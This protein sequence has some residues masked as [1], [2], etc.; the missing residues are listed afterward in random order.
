M[1]NSEIASI[2][3]RMADILEFKGELIFK[4]NAY[5]KA[6]RVLL[7]GAEDIEILAAQ[8]RL[9]ELPGIGKAIQE[10]ILEYLREK[11][12]AKYEELLATVPRELFELLSIPNYGPKTA[13]LAY[14]ELGIETLQDLKAAIDK[15]SLRDLPG[16]GDKKVEK[17]RQGIELRESASERISIGIALPIVEEVISYLRA[18]GGDRILQIAPAGS[19]R[20]FR[21][22]VHDID[23]LVETAVSA[24]IIR[25]FTEMPQVT[26][27][28]AAGE[29]KGSVLLDDRFQVDLRAVSPGSFGAA[30]QYFTGSKEHNVRLR[31]LARKKGLKINE[32]G[33]FAGEDKVAGEDEEALYAY[34]GMAWIAPEL[35]EDRGE[36]EAAVAQHLPNLVHLNELLGDLHIHSNQSDGHLTMEDMAAAV[37][38]RGYRY[39]AFCDHSQSAFYANG[40]SSERLQHSKET[41]ARL[42]EKWDDFVVLAGAEVEILADGRLDYSDEIL[43]ELDFVVASIHSGFKSDPTGRTIAA[44][45][46]PYIDLIGHPTGRLISRRKGLEI[47]LDKVIESAVLTGTALEVNSS[48]DRLDLQELHIKNAIEAGAKI[49]IN[50]DAHDS[51]QLDQ[52]QFGVAT[53]RRG[54]ATAKDVINTLSLER[55]KKWQKRNR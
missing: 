27:I 9:G 53:A 47:D 2:F 46:N 25:L 10:K 30:L 39:M 5:R 54:W 40:L 51:S 19:V 24:E 11:R 8:N 50:T 32:Y 38:A 13:A 3:D 4:I 36:I 7:E 12:I 35:R 17:I 22:T 14:R 52:M 31:E 21:E 16:M 1:K 18:T 29:T 44:M 41:I 33:V 55:L 34:L 6:S 45:Q 15:G 20:R 26:R 37:R 49:C 23:V 42:N 43:K 28:L 48:W